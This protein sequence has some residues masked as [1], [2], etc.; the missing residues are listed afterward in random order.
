MKFGLVSDLHLE[1]G[2][3]D[4]HFGMGNTLLVAG[5]MQVAAYLISQH[6]SVLDQDMLGRSHR[7]ITNALE[8]YDNVVAV[9][10]NHESYH[11]ILQHTPA[12]VRKAL[13][14]FGG[15][16]HFLENDLIHID[17]Q[18]IFGATMWTD[19]NGNDRYT[20]ERLRNY[21]ADYR[22]IAYHDEQDLMEYRDLQP[23]DLYEEHLASRALLLQAQSEAQAAGKPLVVV[24]HH[25]PSKRS[26]HPR[27]VKD[28]TINGGYSTN[29]EHMMG[30]HTP[31]WVH[32]HTHDNHDYVVNG[33][34]VVC[35][36][37]G[38]VG[39]HLNPDFIPDLLLEI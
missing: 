28:T 20:K 35:N 21:M 24:T 22:H 4:R 37:R 29:L 2:E 5:D 31:L 16:F 23:D 7:F 33:T 19:F 26:T 25:A 9:A 10:G 18:P 11:G 36:P 3:Y 13:G 15:R 17:G 6:K 38:Y 39:H 14:D 12:M 30:D 1:F 8:N 34:R 27:Y 32:G